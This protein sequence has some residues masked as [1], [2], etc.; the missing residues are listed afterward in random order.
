MK[1]TIGLVMRNV[2][3]SVF[4][5]WPKLETENLNISASAASVL[6]IFI[7]WLFEV[8][9]LKQYSTDLS[10]DIIDTVHLIKCEHPQIKAESQHSNLRVTI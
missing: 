4:K 6:S 8:S 5:A 7:I 1:D 10:L 2:G 3:S 9:N